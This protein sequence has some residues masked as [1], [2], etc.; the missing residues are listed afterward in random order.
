M[1]ARKRRC[2][3]HP[4]SCRRRVVRDRHDAGLPLVQQWPRCR[5]QSPLHHRLHGARADDRAGLGAGG[6]RSRRGANVFATV[7][8][9]RFCSWRR[10]AD[11][12]LVSS[13]GGTRSPNQG[14]F[15]T[16][17]LTDLVEEACSRNSRRFPSAVACWA[18]TQVG[19]SLRP[20][21]RR[22]P[23]PNADSRR[24]LRRVPRR[25]GT[26][27]VLVWGSTTGSQSHSRPLVRSC[28]TMVQSRCR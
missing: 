28:A 10:E 24:M 21:F 9:D 22:V 15:V 16:E 1:V 13:S 17:E 18:L 2:V 26:T 7:M 23:S 12:G 4:R 5:A 6:P 11:S 27:R 8:C 19:N 14:S 3:L 20:R 25:P